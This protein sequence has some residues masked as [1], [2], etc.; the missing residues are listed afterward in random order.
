[1]ASTDSIL[2]ALTVARP[3]ERAKWADVG[4]SEFALLLLALNSVVIA[5]AVALFWLSGLGLGLETKHTLVGLWPI[6]MA[7]SVW[8]YYAWMPGSPREWTIPQAAL[9]FVLVQAAG[10]VC[11]PMQ[12]AAAALNRPTID[13]ILAKADAWFGVSVPAL[14]AWTA[15]H[16]WLVAVLSWA[17]F[18]FLYQLFVP[19]FVLPLWNDS[20]AL[21]EFAFHMIVCG[22]ITI[23]AFTL[24]PAAGVF[25]E[26]GFQSLIDQTRFM[27]HFGALRDGSMTAVPWG[28]LEGLVSVPSFHMAGAV[29]VTWACRRTWLVWILVPLNVLLIA[30]TV[31]LGAHYAIDLVASGLMLASSLAFYRWVCRHIRKGTSRSARSN[32]RKAGSCGTSSQNA[33]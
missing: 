6:A 24:W 10:M 4:C 16:P 29:I 20:E 22:L 23:A 9:V 14:V 31:L 30:A 25:T 5:F 21:W 11:T 12:Y 13:P 27:T 19:I 3:R 7:L 15:T 28:D 32:P 1:M 2:V 8:A 18:S 26:L 17:Y 33:W